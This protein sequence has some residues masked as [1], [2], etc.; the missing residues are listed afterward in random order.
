MESAAS[1]S[2]S[3]STPSM[4][5]REPL[6]IRIPTDVPTCKNNLLEWLSL[7]VEEMNESSQS[8]I[9]HCWDSTK[10]ST[11]WN[12]DVQAEA[13]RR[14]EEIFP[15][16]VRAQAV[17]NLYDRF[18]HA[19]VSGTRRRDGSGRGSCSLRGRRIG[20]AGSRSGWRMMRGPQIEPDARTDMGWTTGFWARRTGWP[21]QIL[22][23][24]D[25]PPHRVLGR[26]D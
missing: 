1:E 16:L 22:G 21:R 19:S 2:A 11:A 6:R 23:R 14:A 24:R 20:W 7:L 26:T 10:L 4:V 17:Q 9:T 12:H 5:T 3:R 25:V 18:E 8:G 13:L 15:N